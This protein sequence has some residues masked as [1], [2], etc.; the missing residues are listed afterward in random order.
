VVD[1]LMSPRA[2]VRSLQK[3]SAGGRGSSR[4]EAKVPTAVGESR[5]DRRPSATQSASRIVSKRETKFQEQYLNHSSVSP[6]RY[7][8][9]FA[10]EL[11]VRRS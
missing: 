11:L 6:A 4:N 3:A 7:Y 1:G 8:D 5:N 9:E 2:F 10:A